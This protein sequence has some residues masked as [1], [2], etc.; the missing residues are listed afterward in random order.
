MGK[1]MKKV[2][3][4]RGWRWAGRAALIYLTVQTGVPASTLEQAIVEGLRKK[5]HG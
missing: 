5:K 1:K 2:F 4:W 3:N